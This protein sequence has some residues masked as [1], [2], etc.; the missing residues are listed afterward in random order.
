MN[1]R[2]LSSQAA[3][4]KFPSKKPRSIDGAAE[5]R[6]GPGC[7]GGGRLTLTAPTPTRRPTPWPSQDGRRLE[8]QRTGS[9]GPLP[10]GPDFNTSLG[11]HTERGAAKFP[12]MEPRRPPLR[13]GE[14]PG[15]AKCPKGKG[16]SYGRDTSSCPGKL[17]SLCLETRRGLGDAHRGALPE[18]LPGGAVNMMKPG[19]AG[20]AQP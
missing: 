18:L 3:G 11:L 9:W 8:A 15:R 1:F 5:R 20:G 6:A 10:A 19:R 17:P 2:L 12:A 16:A 14:S 13:A 4:V 7:R